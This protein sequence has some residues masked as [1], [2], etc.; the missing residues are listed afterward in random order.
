MFFGIINM[1]SERMANVSLLI[2]AMKNSGI[3]NPY[4]Q[5]AILGVVGKESKFI[6]KDE[7]CY[8]GTSNER[9][10]EIF[11]GKV[12]G[13]S[14]SGLTALKNDCEA[15]FNVV[16]GGR[17]GNMGNDGYKYRG[18]GFNQLTFR[19]SYKS[20]GDKIGQNLVS[21]PDSVNDPYV[22]SKVMIAFLKGRFAQT[23]YVKQ[24]ID[25]GIANDAPDLD[26][27]IRV[28]AH[29]NAGWG[30]SSSGS[31][32]TRAIENAYPIA[33]DALKKKIGVPPAI[34]DPDFTPNFTPNFKPDFVFNP[35]KVKLPP[36]KV[37]GY[38]IDSKSQIYLLGAALVVIGLGIVLVRRKS[39]YIPD[40]S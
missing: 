26:S 18:R 4:L 40:Y 5:A 39:E 37:A 32:V 24:Y 6:P 8:N 13:Y 7:R 36:V 1:N 10:R 22:A 27:A 23:Q 17:Y 11:G 21:N 20:I 30:K 29:A 28:V 16:Y 2:D 14:P 19:G 31:A 25:N 15:F 34:A 33:E 12:S 9:I 35:V 38:T 3:T